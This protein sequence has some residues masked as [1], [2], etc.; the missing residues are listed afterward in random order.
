MWQLRRKRSIIFI[1]TP[2]AFLPSL[3]SLTPQLFAKVFTNER[4][5]IEMPR[6]VRI[7]PGEEL[8]SS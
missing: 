6:I 3:G 1:E 5:R 8:C 4:V 7:F 2:V